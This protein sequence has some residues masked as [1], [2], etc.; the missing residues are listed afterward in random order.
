M[1][2]FDLADRVFAE[3]CVYPSQLKR[4]NVLGSVASEHRSS[5][6]PNAPMGGKP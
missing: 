3:D 1:K 2:F 6:A 4:G 5:T